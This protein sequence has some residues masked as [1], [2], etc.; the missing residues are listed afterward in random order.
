MGEHERPSSGWEDGGGGREKEELLTF[1]PWNLKKD[2][3]PR[4]CSR[5]ATLV[6]LRV[7]PLPC[8]V[9]NAVSPRRA[10]SSARRRRAQ[11]GARERRRRTL[12]AAR[13]GAVS[14][15]EVAPEVFYGN[16]EALPDVGLGTSD[17][18]R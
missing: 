5:D 10:Q 8:G 16:G 14:F 4:L 11:G 9:M 13:C 1:R 6:L 18:G 15:A 12:I 17:T 2:L 3:H 7:Q